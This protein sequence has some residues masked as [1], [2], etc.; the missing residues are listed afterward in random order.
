[1]RP[2]SPASAHGAFHLPPAA[3]GQTQPTHP[4]KVFIEKAIYFTPPLP[5]PVSGFGTKGRV[6][7]API[8]F[9]SSLIVTLLSYIEA[10]MNHAKVT[11]PATTAVQS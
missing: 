11:I 3:T 6:V 8:F 2:P 7:D 9:P 5:L 1:M 10:R 4:L